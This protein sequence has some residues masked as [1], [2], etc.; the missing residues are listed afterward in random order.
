MDVKYNN[1]PPDPLESSLS[2]QCSLGKPM[3]HL[4]LPPSPI[5]LVSDAPTQNADKYREAVSSTRTTD[6]AASITG[7]GGEQYWGQRTD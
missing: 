1:L 6:R 7:S 3:V 2:Q 4:P 5:V